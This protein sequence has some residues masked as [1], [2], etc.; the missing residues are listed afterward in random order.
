MERKSAVVL[1][2]SVLAHTSV[3]AQQSS[4]FK[5]VEQAFNAGGHPRDGTV[6]VSASFRI[7]LDAIGD[8]VAAAALSSS[9]FHMGGGFVSAYPPP[10]EVLGLLFTDEENLAWGIERSVGTYAIYRAATTTLPGL[11]YGTC[12]DSA[13]T[14]ESYTDSDL[15]SSDQAFFYLVTALNLLGEEGTKGYDSFGAERPNPAPCP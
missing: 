10:G 3:L 11:G 15:P 6:L 13:L 5:L 8:P 2:L 9:S 12:L 14:D 1:A 7:R 4:N